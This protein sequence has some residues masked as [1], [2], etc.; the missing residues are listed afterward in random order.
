MQLCI[1]AEFANP[2][3]TIVWL[4]TVVHRHMLTLTLLRN[5]GRWPEAHQHFEVDVALAGLAIGLAAPGV[6]TT[7]SL[8]LAPQVD[9]VMGIKCVVH[10]WSAHSWIRRDEPLVHSAW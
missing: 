3:D 6:P 5:V 1:P 10:N 9:G 2:P 4:I 7:A 8:L